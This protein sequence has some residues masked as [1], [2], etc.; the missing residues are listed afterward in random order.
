MR[1]AMDGSLVVPS[2]GHRRVSESAAL[3]DPH[4][5][6]H[7]ESGGRRRNDGLPAPDPHKPPASAE[8]TEPP[9]K[10]PTTKTVLRRLREA[11]STASM[12]V[13]V[14]TMVDWMP[15]E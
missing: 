12:R 11:G 3:H 8:P 6:G 4:D 15:I 9:M 14:S 10:L 1:K 7:P 5:Q 13:W 2:H